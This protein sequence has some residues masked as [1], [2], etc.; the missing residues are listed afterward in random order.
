MIGFGVGYGCV[1]MNM[2]CLVYNYVLW[3]VSV[4]IECIVVLDDMIDLC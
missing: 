2:L 4:E 1:V 3:C